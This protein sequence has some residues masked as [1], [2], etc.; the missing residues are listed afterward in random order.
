MDSD[1]DNI[2][3]SLDLEGITNNYNTWSH[4]AVHK[5]MSSISFL[6]VAYEPST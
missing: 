1:K 3:A 6:N 5:Q 4:F 2:V